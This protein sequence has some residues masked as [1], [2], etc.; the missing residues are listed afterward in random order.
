M[1]AARGTPVGDRDDPDQGSAEASGGLID[2]PRVWALFISVA[3]VMIAVDQISKVLAVRHLTGE[4]DVQVV[5]EILQLHLTYNPGAAFSLGTRFTAVLSCLA[6]V[7][8]VVIL[9][10]SRRLA[11][12]LW[13][14]A[15]GLLLAAVAG[16]LLDRLFRDPDPFRGHVVDFL[17]LPNWPVFNVA[18]VCINIGIGLILIQLLRGVNTAGV[19]ETAHGANASREDPA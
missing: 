9:W 6:I 17:M 3:A 15:M 11:S 18:D 2:R 19:R 8:T 5:G 12:R 7:A 16:N 4:P 10:I 1:Q 13:A 14:V